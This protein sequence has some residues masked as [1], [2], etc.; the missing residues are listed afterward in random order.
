MKKIQSV[1]FLGIGG[2]G[3][4]ALARY[5]LF[6]GKKVGG[7]DKTSSALTKTLEKEGMDIHYEDDV[8]RIPDYCKGDPA[9]TLVI[10]T[11]A[12]P[13]D[14]AEWEW[15]FQKGYRIIKRA[16]ALGEISAEK[17]SVAISG[18]HGKTS[19]TTMTSYLLQET[20]IGC[21]AFLGGISKNYQ[22]N[23]LMQ[24]DSEWVVIEADEFDRS[25]HWLHPK[26]ALI[27]SM[28]ADHLDIYGDHEQVRHSF[29]IFTER[30]DSQ[31]IL[32]TKMG[33]E[34]E[35]RTRARRYRYAL[36]NS[37]ADF[38][39][40]NLHLEEG[41]YCFDFQTPLG[42]FP[43]FRVGIP[44]L[45]NVE[46]AVAAMAIAVLL[47]A[48]PSEI[49]K[50]MPGFMGVN[51]RFDLRFRS[52]SVLYIDDYAHHPEELRFTLQSIRELYPGRHIT[53]VFQP[54]LY[55][56][57][58]DFAE[59]FAQSLELADAL[60]LLEIYPARELPLEGV[61]A[62]MILDRVSLEDKALCSMQNILQVVEARKI[63]ILATL[64][65]GDIDRL[66]DPIVHLL[67]NKT[68]CQCGEI[69]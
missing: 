5:F 45:V 53:A 6:M 2:I 64:G 43:D 44:G 16:V 24:K 67:Q 49:R 69:S 22:T 57:T 51:R 29:S 20:G 37:D 11:P 13:S 28:D 38:F 3:M 15:F 48:D 66:A 52:S 21:D 12:V 4:S 50:A 39:A 42:R 30:V 40:C 63:D 26:L 36:T 56:R 35:V 41:L 23:L 47:G 59:G 10:V 46:N 25:F 60:L 62:S 8:T 19:I 55:S 9:Q 31:G 61:S 27:S 58:R 7:Y 17:K 34:P 33:V 54:H 18:T 14:L 32:I 65:A 68:Q 1:Y